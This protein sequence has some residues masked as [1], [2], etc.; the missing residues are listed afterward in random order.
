MNLT[1]ALL[2]STL[3]I[4]LVR[5]ANGLASRGLQVHLIS[6]HPLDHD[7]DPQITLHTLPFNAPLGYVSSSMAL[8]RLLKQLKPDLLNAHYATGYGLLARLS[9]FKP[10]LLSIWGSDIYDVPQESIFHRSLVVT[11]LRAA[12]AIASTSRCMLKR[13]E[14]LYPHPITF[15]TPFGIDE[16]LFKNSRSPIEKHTR[17]IHIGCIKSLEPVYGIDIVLKAFALAV[18][19]LDDEYSLQLSIAGDGGDSHKLQKLAQFLELGDKVTF[20]GQVAHEDVPKLLNEIDIFVAL[21][22][23]ESFGVSI[24][25]ASACEVPVIVSDADGPAEVTVNGQTGI[26]IPKND[27]TAAC[28][29]IIELV[30]NRD[31][32]LSMGRAGRRHVIDQYTWALSVDRMLD[33]YESM[34][35][36]F[37]SSG[38]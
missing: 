29:A 28:N 6:C 18:N 37:R 7:L 30:R 13:A 16:A 33:A 19:T 8:R 2:G 4:H 14:Q 10:C 24:L 32:R 36:V 35:R 17:E 11:N 3:S 26:V 5:W 9:G 31:L 21:S 38:Q 22:R 27:V 23:E 34:L 25:E 12:T 20:L 1:V 15:I